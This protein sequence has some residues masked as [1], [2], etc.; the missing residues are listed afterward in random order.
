MTRLDRHVPIEESV[1]HYPRSVAFLIE[2]GLPYLVCGDP[3]WG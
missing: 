3:T 2:K 1:T